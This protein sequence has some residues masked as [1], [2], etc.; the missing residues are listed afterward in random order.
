ME[1]VE[2]QQEKGEGRL[3]SRMRR[4]RSKERR[5]PRLMNKI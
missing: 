5:A 3:K 4:R 1:G 2:E